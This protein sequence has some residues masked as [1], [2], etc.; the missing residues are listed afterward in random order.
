MMVL[1]VH[2]ARLALVVFDPYLSSRP[3]AKALMESPPGALITQG[4]YWKLASVFFYTGHNGLL[5]S[6]RRINLEYGASAPG[7]PE[8]FID[9]A[10]FRDLGL[11]PHRYYLLASQSAL[12]HC[13]TLVGASRLIV[14]RE[15]GGKVLMTNQ[16]GQ[17]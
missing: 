7:A 13:E 4:F 17:F 14:V 8:V 2:A 1:F 6:D 3:L 11:E 5:L 9:D 15:S 16:A 12:P 10:Q